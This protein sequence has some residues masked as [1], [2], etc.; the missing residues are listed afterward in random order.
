MKPERDI[1]FYGS[2][3]LGLVYT[4]LMM[5]GWSMTPLGPGRIDMWESVYYYCVPFV[6][7]MGVVA[8]ALRRT[9]RYPWW[10]G[11]GLLAYP[12]VA[13]ALLA[14]PHLPSSARLAIL[15]PFAGIT[16]GQVALP[17]VL[18]WALVFGYVLCSIPVLY[19][20]RKR[21]AGAST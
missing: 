6:G 8:L 3:I 10:L 11:V 17:D 7:A 4:G 9:Q 1:L 19:V 2:T 13:F 20:W 18:L 5:L 12:I 16:F 21:G 15:W 14:V